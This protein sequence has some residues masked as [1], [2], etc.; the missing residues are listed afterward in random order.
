[1]DSGGGQRSSTNYRLYHSIGQASGVAT[2][3]NGQY[4]NAAGFYASN[5][6]ALGDSLLVEMLQ[7]VTDSLISYT[8]RVTNFFEETLFVMIQDALDAYVD[9]VAG[10]LRVNGTGVPDDELFVSDGLLNYLYAPL[11]P[12]DML[13]LSYTVTVN[14]DAPPGWMIEN[15]AL[16][17]GYTDPN[18]PFTLT[19]KGPT[20]PEAYQTAIPE[21]STLV[22]FCAGLV[23]VFVLA[24]K[25]MKR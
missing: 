17:T 21:P 12:D 3:S 6:Q 8:I 10:S 19:F 9:Y 15:I 2:S 14:D 1:M 24:R 16:I 23:G 22:L 13:A 20:N 18:N 25:R 11:D 4:T 7:E 5:V